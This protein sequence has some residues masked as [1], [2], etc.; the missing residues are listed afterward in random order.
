[1]M[2]NTKLLQGA[3]LLMVSTTVKINLICDGLFDVR[4]ALP[5]PPLI[6]KSINSILMTIYSTPYKH[7]SLYKSALD[8]KPR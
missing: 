8:R 2:M 3:F 1:M 6:S 4:Y 5:P 7:C